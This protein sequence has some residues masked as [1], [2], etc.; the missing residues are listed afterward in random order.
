MARATAYQEKNTIVDSF[1]QL[2]GAPPISDISFTHVMR[3][4]AH[5]TTSPTPT[6]MGQL[7]IMTL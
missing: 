3:L 4:A 2:P 6:A 7:F 5:S 1:S